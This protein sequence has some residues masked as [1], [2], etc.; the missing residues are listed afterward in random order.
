MPSPDKPLITFALF[1]YNQESFIRKAVE[2]AFSQTYSPLEIILSDDCS[3]DHT[4]EIMK[5]MAAAYSGPHKLL[6]NRNT[7]NLG[8][9]H[10]FS[11]VM[12]LVTGEIIELAAGDDISLPY[13]T[14]ES[15]KILRTNPKIT[16]VSLGLVEF[17]DEP[18]FPNSRDTEG[19]IMTV[20]NV[21]EWVNGIGLH[22]NAPARAFRRFTHD[23]FGPLCKDCPV[24]DGPNLFRCLLHGQAAF[25]PLK[26]VLY[27]RHDKAMSTPHNLRKIKFNLIYKE[28][29]HSL[30]IAYGRGLISERRRKILWS[31]LMSRLRKQESQADFVESNFSARCYVQRILF[32][33]S[34]STREKVVQ[35]RSLI[36]NKCQNV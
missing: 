11:R 19:L 6:L 17:T 22:I 7:K 13:R 28:Y 18:V 27:R 24:E 26:A 36:R 1:G 32:S 21:S 9:G 4:F 15:W 31:K 29:E 34:F 33:R 16:C 25:F 23:Y 14:E 3:T 35:L 5:E 10:H 30:K 2:G 12:E 20:R 8:I